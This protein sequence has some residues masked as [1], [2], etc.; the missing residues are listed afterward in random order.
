MQKI[1]VVPTQNH[2]K[3]IGLDFN[4]FPVTPDSSYYFVSNKVES[5]L[6]ELIHCIEARKG[7]M[8]VTGDVGKGKTTLSRR[9]ITIL[10]EQGTQVS[11][12]FNSFLHGD[13]LLEA[14]NRDFGIICENNI[15]AQLQALNGYLLNL[16]QK[17]SNC[18]IVIDDAQHLDVQ[19]LELVRQ[20]SNLETNHAKLVQIILIAQPEILNT[21]DYS[22]I[23]QLK[24]RIALHVRLDAFSQKEVQDYISYRLSVAGNCR[25][26]KITRP[27]LKILT[28]A[29]GGIPRRI[30]LI[31]DRCLYILS[32]STRSEICE[33][34]I[35]KS[36]KDIGWPTSKRSI[37]PRLY[38]LVGV[39]LL[40]STAWLFI[41]PNKFSDMAARSEMIINQ[42]K[43]NH[44]S[45]EFLPNNH[46]NAYMDE[47]IYTDHLF[48]QGKPVFHDNEDLEF[49]NNDSNIDQA[50]LDFLS[51]YDL[52]D[53]YEVFIEAVYKD[54]LPLFER[55][56]RSTPWK[57]IVSDLPM[58]SEQVST[59]VYITPESLGAKKWLFLWEPSYT[60]DNWIYG[61][62]SQEVAKIQNVLA[63]EGFYQTKVDGIVGPRTKLAVAQFQKSIGLNAT[64]EPDLLTLSQLAAA[65]YYH[66]Q[67]KTVELQ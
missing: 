14:I 26:I 57:L 20:I 48:F 13:S 7:F 35:I 34:D 51:L 56:L 40:V 16:Y 58:D 63:L 65:E 1:G 2:L 3:R 50:A 38:S 62:Y 45:P 67:Q 55:E 46:Q 60:L 6:T 64:G 47:I 31:M 5:N 9:L 41:S 32:I 39:I 27:A 61:E 4:P 53:K 59:A 36:V 49:F 28:E 19:S 22:E 18:V 29:S 33:Q 44:D 17:G 11:L 52:E 12:V 37:A 24:S 15:G 23:R 10:K 25:R 43:M 42:N 66:S 21:L 54:F 8:L 30:N